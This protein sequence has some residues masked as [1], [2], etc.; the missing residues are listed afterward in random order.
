[1]ESQWHYV[2][3]EPHLKTREAMQGEFFSAESIKNAAHALVRESIQNSLDQRD[4][5]SVRIRIHLSG[6][7]GAVSSELIQKYLNGATEHL[8]AEGNGLTDTPSNGDRCQFVVIEDFNTTGLKGD[9]LQWHDVPGIKN[10]FYFF[11]RAEGRSGKSETDRGRWGIGK[12]VFPRSSRIKS[13]FGLTIRSDDHKRLLM[14]QAILRSHM[15]GDTPYS[16][17]GW[18]GLPDKKGL[19]LPFEDAELI[20]RFCADFKISRTTEPGLS[21]VIPFCDE[22]LTCESFVEAV[23]REYF[24]SILSGDLSVEIDMFDRYILLDA[25]SLPDMAEAL[26]ETAKDLPSLVKLAKWSLNAPEPIPELIC[27]GIDGAIKWT[28]DLIPPTLA[29]AA[30]EILQSGEPLALKVPLKIREKK[31]KA[32]QDSYFRVFLQRDDESG[33]G[34]TAFVRKGIIIS[35][36]RAPRARGYRALVL[37]DDQALTSLLGDAENPAHTQWQSDSSNFKNK[38]VYGPS[39]LKFV[40]NS[41]Y[42]ILKVFTEEGQKE[43]P[44][45]LLDLFYIDSPEKKDEKKK[46]T[47]KPEEPPPPPPP[48][49][50][51]AFRL[52]KISGGFSITKGDPGAAA[53]SIIGI[54]VAY[55]RRTGNPFSRYSK[56]DFRLNVSPIEFEPPPVGVEIL[57]RKENRFVLKVLDPEFSVSVKGFDE[58]RDIIVDARAVKEES[59]ATQD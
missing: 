48:P 24:L 26:M 55:D 29:A 13:F 15:L 19:V 31:K 17:D 14:G 40:S 8:N 52:Q 43:D 6:N 53:P 28:V 47:K 23:T 57:T 12:F 35:D 21:I 7:D 46:K 54:R 50:P 36:V 27:P 37:I 56:S 11:F 9:P 59:Y 44:T 38:Y 30:T 49:K 3:L 39:Y 32:P 42:E 2:Q 10:H 5:G 16:P 51:K 20:D 34:K 25:E 22:D 45:A 4:G 1:M 41:V 33:D 18:F 58:K